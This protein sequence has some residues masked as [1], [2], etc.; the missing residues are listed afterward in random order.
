MGLPKTAQKSS[1]GRW[2]NDENICSNSWAGRAPVARGA[3][4]MVI[5]IS[6]DTT[7]PLAGTATTER[8]AHVPFTGWLELLRAISALV[9]SSAI[10]GDPGQSA[11][12]EL[13]V[14]SSVEHDPT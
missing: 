3:A 9:D 6:V 2:T 5:Q 12:A 1:Q 13:M 4:D 7:D 14:R 11:P 10:A 8:G